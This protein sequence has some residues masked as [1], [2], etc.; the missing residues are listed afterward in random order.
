MKPRD[1]MKQLQVCKSK[2]AKYEVNTWKCTDGIIFYQTLFN[3]RWSQLVHYDDLKRNI[4]GFKVLKLSRATLDS[5]R[6]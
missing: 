5:H 3:R 6:V 4:T 2:C 1:G